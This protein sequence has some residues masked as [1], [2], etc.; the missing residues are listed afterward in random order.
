MDHLD[1]R[2]E[3]RARSA[4]VGDQH[5]ADRRGLVPDA[6]PQ[7]N[8]RRTSSTLAPT[9]CPSA[10]QLGDEPQ[11]SSDRTARPTA[12]ANLTWCS[13][14]V[15]RLDAMGQMHRRM[16]GTPPWSSRWDHWME[17][18]GLR[19]IK[20]TVVAR[21]YTIRYVFPARSVADCETGADEV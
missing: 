2:R 3:R 1:A 9:A 21:K 7:A 15:S 8:N 20:L 17:I 13:S 18:D 4:R 5:G 6:R 14:A 12:R 11:A 16:A 10:T 19:R